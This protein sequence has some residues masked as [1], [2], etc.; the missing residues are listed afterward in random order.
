M[1]GVL[2]LASVMPLELA[3]VLGFHFAVKEV[4]EGETSIPPETRFK[5][6]EGLSN[7]GVMKNLTGHR[8]H[9]E[10]PKISQINP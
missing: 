10:S 5:L 4:W 2:I 7:Q 1:R 3:P 9:V 6:M 8:M